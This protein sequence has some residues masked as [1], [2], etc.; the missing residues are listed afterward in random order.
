MSAPGNNHPSEN[1][2]R[3]IFVFGAE[4]MAL[5]EGQ[6]A[7]PESSSHF[8]HAIGALAIEPGYKNHH[9]VYSRTLQRAIGQPLVAQV[10]PDDVWGFGSTEEDHALATVYGLKNEVMKVL[11]PKQWLRIGV[12][13]VD[14]II[15]VDRDETTKIFKRFTPLY[16][17]RFRNWIGKRARGIAARKNATEDEVLEALD[18]ISSAVRYDDELRSKEL[19]K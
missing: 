10:N 9:G 5:L 18:I 4:R 1:S 16:G 19:E 11:L 14:E 6:E 2:Q 8:L 15:Y 17:T 12:Y 7:T 13:E 3:Q